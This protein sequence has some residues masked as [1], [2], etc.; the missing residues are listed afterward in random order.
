MAKLIP[1]VG[2]PRDGELVEDF[3]PWFREPA[4][5]RP[6]IQVYDRSEPISP[7][8]PAIDFRLYRKERWSVDWSERYVLVTT[9]LGQPSFDPGDSEYRRG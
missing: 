2:G 4:P 1:L 5:K 9:D 6:R 7:T 3:G 8:G